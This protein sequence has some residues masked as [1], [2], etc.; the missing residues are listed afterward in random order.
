MFY[1]R[2]A[3]FPC[4]ACATPH[5]AFYYAAYLRTVPSAA[6]RTSAL[7]LLLY[8]V[9]P[10]CL[11]NC[12]FYCAAYLCTVPSVALHTSAPVPFTGL[13]TSTLALWIACGP[14]IR[15]KLTVLQCA[16]DSQI[17]R[18]YHALERSRLINR[19]AFNFTLI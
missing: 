19:Y 8:C 7:C 5:Y 6:L 17:H 18:S 16:T 15:A 4:L 12:A 9:P 3:V 1:E 11:R 13:R 10:L 14:L 2:S